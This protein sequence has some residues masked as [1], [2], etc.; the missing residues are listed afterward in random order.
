MHAYGCTFHHSVCYILWI[1]PRCLIAFATYTAYCPFVRI[2][3]LNI[4]NT[5]SIYLYLLGDWFTF[6]KVISSET[7]DPLYYSWMFSRILDMSLSCLQVLL[8]C[9]IPIG[10]SEPS[11]GKHSRILCIW[12]PESYSLLYSLLSRRRPDRTLNNNSSFCKR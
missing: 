9:H 6:N 2:C 10:L 1:K 8:F 3:K 4:P 12:Q 11:R 7:S 5:W